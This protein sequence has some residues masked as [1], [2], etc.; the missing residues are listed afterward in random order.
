MN[1]PKHNNGKC[2]DLRILRDIKKLIHE[3]VHYDLRGWFMNK[4]SSF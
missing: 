3:Q 4:I 1:A 2:V